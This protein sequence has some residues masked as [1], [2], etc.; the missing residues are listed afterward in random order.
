[1]SNP[2]DPGVMAQ[3]LLGVVRAYRFIPRVGPPRCRFAPTCSAY[4]IDA[5]QRHGAGC[6]SWLTLRRLGRCH[7]FNPGGF[8]PVPGP[9]EEFQRV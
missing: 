4:A 5:I 6:G 9:S 8:D 2:R 1:V 7:P 3:L